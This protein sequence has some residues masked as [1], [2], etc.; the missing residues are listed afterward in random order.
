MFMVVVIHARLFNGVPTHDSKLMLGAAAV[1][2]F[3]VVS[4]FVITIMNKRPS[5]LYDR[6]WR[7]YPLWLIAVTPW[8]LTYPTDG[9]TL[10]ASLTLWPVFGGMVTPTLGV[11]WTLS[12]DVLFYVAVAL[13]ARTGVK[14][15]LALYAAML[16]GSLFSKAPIFD[17][18]GNPMMIEVLFGAVL[19]KLPRDRRLAVPL[20]LAAVVLF[21]LSPTWVAGRELAVRAPASAW[22]VLYWGIPATL[23]VYGCLCGEEGFKH[24][25]WNGL[26]L[27]GTASYSIYLFHLTVIDR[28]SL[29][30]PAEV[31][32]AIGVGMALW[33]FVE[34]PVTAM[35]PRW[36][37]RV[38]VPAE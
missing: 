10:A 34:R 35:K 4:G 31:A 6:C 7:I 30:W 28:I 16:A 29:P 32:V 8:L 15:L 2:V 19:A 37:R 33:W 23:L 13:S 9:K 24:R 11:G 18:L 21:A 17:F 25:A 14:P 38:L 12:F 1:D 26:V 20:I 27:L 22:R 5:F 3:F 36:R